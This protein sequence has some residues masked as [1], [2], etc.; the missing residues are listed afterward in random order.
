MS[1]NLAVRSNLM[2]DD[3]QHQEHWRYLPGDFVKQVYPNMVDVRTI[4]SYLNPQQIIEHQQYLVC[5]RCGR[6]CAGTC[7][8][9]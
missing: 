6:P 4:T 5:I 8:S 9:R 1:S 2:V 7:V 3:D